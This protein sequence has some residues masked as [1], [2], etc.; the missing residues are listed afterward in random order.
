M[1]QSERM[2]A[3]SSLFLRMSLMLALVTQTFCFLVL[4]LFFRCF[5]RFY[6]RSKQSLFF[7]QANRMHRE[8]IHR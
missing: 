1:L 6:I 8:Y 7:S 3:A 4:A 2:F 5:D